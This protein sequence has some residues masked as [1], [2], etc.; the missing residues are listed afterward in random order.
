MEM[1]QYDFMQRALVASFCIAIIAPIIGLLLLLRRQSLLADTLSHISLSGVALGLIVHVSPTLMTMVVVIIASLLIEYLRQVYKA[2][3]EVSVAILMATGL[4]V[5]L[6]LMNVRPNG[7]SGL[8]VE[9]YLFGS[10]VIVSAEQVIILIVLAI[11]I[12]LLYIIF[13]RPLYVLL[14]DEDTAYT[15]GL[16]VR[17]MSVLFTVI[18]G[19]AISLM[20]PIAGALLVASI[21]ILPTAI[22]M[23]FAKNFTSVILWGMG[24]SIMGMFSGLYT[25]Y[26]YNTPPGA[27]I[28][29]IFVL[30][31]IVV[32][33]SLS[34]YKWIVQRKEH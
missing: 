3:S 25:S 23:R 7:S 15:T 20:M 30:I 32:T 4:A 24:I 27:T 2:Y 13:K 33:I 26:E 14:F 5:S 31:L 6:M 9:Q 19:L 10:L 11:L 1:F 21:L 12:A 18:V 22:A 8:K 16:P 34:I 29:L 28:T 17:V